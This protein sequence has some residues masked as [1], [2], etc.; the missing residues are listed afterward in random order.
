MILALRW[1]ALGFT[2]AIVVWLCFDPPILVIAL[3]GIV[4]GAVIGAA[5]MVI[6]EWMDRVLDWVDE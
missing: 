2:S 6:G 1:F 5:S 3:S 4:S